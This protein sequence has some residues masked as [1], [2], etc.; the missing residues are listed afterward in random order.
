M[1]MIVPF[2]LARRRDFVARQARMMASLK[3]RAA[4]Q[5]LLRQLETQ[6][7]VMQRRGVDQCAVN[8]QTAELA[9]AIRARLWVEVFSNPGGAA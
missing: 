5:Y 4:E 3:P 1:A 2:P 9:Q 6:R 8:E 7:G